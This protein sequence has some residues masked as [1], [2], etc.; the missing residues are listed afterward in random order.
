MAKDTLCC[1][2]LLVLEREAR[3][4]ALTMSPSKAREGARDEFRCRSVSEDKRPA[5]GDIRARAGP[6]CRMNAMFDEGPRK[7][8]SSSSAKL[9]EPMPSVAPSAS[10]LQWLYWNVIA[11]DITIL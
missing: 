11:D 4:D 6:R 9:R 3:L 5:V 7:A 1:T 2:E 10:S 8:A